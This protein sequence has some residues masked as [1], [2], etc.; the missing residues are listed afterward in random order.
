[1]LG[2][3]SLRQIVFEAILIHRNLS[4]CSN[5]LWSWSRLT[6]A[7][8]LEYSYGR[9]GRNGHFMMRTIESM[10]LILQRT[11]KWS[12]LCLICHINTPAYW[13]IVLNLFQLPKEWEYFQIVCHNF[14][15]K[16]C[17]QR[18][19]ILYFILKLEYFPTSVSLG[20]FEQ[21]HVKS[22]DKLLWMELSI[23][24]SDRI[25]EESSQTMFVNLFCWFFQLF[26]QQ[27]H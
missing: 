14:F 16:N 21:S 11:T 20:W 7:P 6:Q 10:E 9:F 23:T 27:I 18:W 19:Y 13:E 25:I 22:I 26:S 15:C 3:V 8:Q 12:E 4:S 5:C 17:L 2:R 1:M 24:A